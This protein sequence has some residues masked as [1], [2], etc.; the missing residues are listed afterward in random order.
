MKGGG[1]S[2]RTVTRK[3]LL[4]STVQQSFRSRFLIRAESMKEGGGTHSL[5][6]QF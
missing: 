1:H 5:H 2:P 3:H 6:Y 4:N